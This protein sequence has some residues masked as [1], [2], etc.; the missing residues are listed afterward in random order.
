VR[1][2][3]WKQMIEDGLLK[4][5]DRICHLLQMNFKKRYIAAVRQTAIH[6]AVTVESM[7]WN[8]LLRALNAEGIHISTCLHAKIRTL[9]QMNSWCLILIFQRYC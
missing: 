9:I 2:K 6:N 4:T 5:T 8:F 7:V 3:T 1:L